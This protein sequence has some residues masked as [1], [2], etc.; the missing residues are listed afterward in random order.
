MLR[1]AKCLITAD[2][3]K[4]GTAFILRRRHYDPFETSAIINRLSHKF[5]SRKARLFRTNVVRT[6]NLSL[7]LS[8][9]KTSQLILYEGKGKAHPRTSHKDSE[10]SRFYIY[11]LFNLG[12]RKGMD[13]QQY[14]CNES[15]RRVRGNV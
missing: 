6:P 5:T 4:D 8:V 12:A 7:T 10:G 14:A 11:C 15:V 2:V 9:T 1:S 3:S 13:G